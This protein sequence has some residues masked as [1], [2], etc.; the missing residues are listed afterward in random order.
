MW[1]QASNQVLILFSSPAAGAASF[2]ARLLRSSPGASSRKLGTDWKTGVLLK[3]MGLGIMLSFDGLVPQILHN[4]DGLGSI[5][6][7]GS[8]TRL[9]R[10][11][12]GVSRESRAP[13][14]PAPCDGLLLLLPAGID[15]LAHANG[16]FGPVAP[17]ESSGFRADGEGGG[18]TTPFCCD[19]AAD[20]PPVD[21]AIE[22]A[23]ETSADPSPCSPGI[24]T[25]SL[26]RGLLRSDCIVFDRVIFCPSRVRLA[27]RDRGLAAPAA[28]SF[29]MPDSE[30]RGSILLRGGD[31]YPG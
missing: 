12:S 29:A 28:G 27:D 26:S 7:F 24:C 11:D 9:G 6:P 17:A 10:A 16:L 14:G 25:L 31:R 13:L 21:T 18:N 5:C 2:S 19:G 4:S 23:A 8:I 30:I 20:G 15:G 3:L 22:S 1:L